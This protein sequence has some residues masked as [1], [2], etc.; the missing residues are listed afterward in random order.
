MNNLLES[1]LK[2]QNNLL[3]SIKNDK[4]IP[5]Q[6][7]KSFNKIINLLN[8]TNLSF[9]KFINFRS[10]ILFLLK[11]INNMVSED[12]CTKCN[13]DDYYSENTLEIVAEMYSKADNPYYILIGDMERVDDKG[14]LI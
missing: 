11:P 7:E 4:K 6:R 10:Y 9:L 12:V 8:E 3:I 2:K 1:Y 5:I 14:N 13:S